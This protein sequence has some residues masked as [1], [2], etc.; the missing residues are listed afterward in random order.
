MAYHAQMRIVT[1]LQYVQTG[2]ANSS[3]KHVPFKRKDFNHGR[4]VLIVDQQSQKHQRCY[5]P[6][7]RTNF[8]SSDFFHFFVFPL[9]GLNSASMPTPVTSEMT[10]F[11]TFVDG[12]KK[13]ISTCPAS[14]TN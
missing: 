2:P 8:D 14:R 4:R 9:S 7:I 13:N 10:N 5:I 12:T 11:F 3:K 6:T 1:K